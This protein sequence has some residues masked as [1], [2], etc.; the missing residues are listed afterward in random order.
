VCRLLGLDAGREPV[1]ASFWLVDAPDS[2]EVQSHRNVDG[3]GIG[4]FDPAGKP[5]IDKQPE[6]AFADGEFARE[7]KQARSATFVAHVRYATAGGRTLANTHPFTMRGRIMAHNGGFGG[8]DRLEEQL[9][10]YLDLVQGDTDSERYF[11][12][13]TQQIDAHGGDVASGIAAAARWIATRLPVSSLN[14]IVTVAGEL[15]ALRYPGQ[16]ALHVIERPAGTSSPPDPGSPAAVLARGSDPPEPPGAPMVPGR[17]AGRPHHGGSPAGTGDAA[18]GLHARST[19][20]SVHAPELHALPSVVVAS[21]EL[22]GE[23]GWRM[24]ASGE[25]VHVRPDL[26]I[27]SAV[28]LPEPP[29]HLVLLPAGNPNID[30]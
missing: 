1:S 21:E 7:A 14:T 29:A 10:S 22:D 15:W 17:Q 25:L 19:T 28:L 27:E 23:H 9:G 13:I 24:L 2:L 12:L 8:L 20:S 11:A 30:T 4:F 6:P 26:S 18:T 16:H 5:V 3:S